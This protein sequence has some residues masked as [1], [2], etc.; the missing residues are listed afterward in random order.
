MGGAIIRHDRLTLRSAEHFGLVATHKDHRESATA[1]QTDRM[2]VIQRLEPPPL[3]VSS[4]D[5]IH[6]HC[7]AFRLRDWKLLI[8][9][10]RI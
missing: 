6:H 3:A 5:A 8:A 1:T 10:T 4:A 2:A 7:H 9:R